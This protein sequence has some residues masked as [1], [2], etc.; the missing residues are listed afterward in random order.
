MKLRRKISVG[1]AV[2]LAAT[3]LGV[4]GTTPAFAAGRLTSNGTC[5]D[6]LDM[7]VQNV[8]DPIGVKV[9]IPSTDPTEVWSVTV[10]QQDYGA[11]TGGR[12]GD[13]VDVTGQF[14]PLVY[15][16]KAQGFSLDGG[17]FTNSE[18][19]THGFSYTATRT[20]PSPLTCTNTNGFWTNPFGTDEGPVSGNPFTRPDAAPLFAGQ[21]EADVG[22]ND[23]LLLM[24]QEM[25]DN[26]LG[27]PANNRFTVT[28]N[29]VAQTVTA[30]QIFN[31]SPPNQAV[32][33][34]TLA[35][36]IP[37]G[38]AV[39]ARYTRALTSGSASLRDLEGLQTA[40]FGPVNISVVGAAAAPQALGRRIR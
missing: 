33:D 6:L 34:L 23:V 30:V 18:G 38:A 12:I 3:T 19:L 27:I 37:S 16:P 4:A 20:S 8:G 39:T 14:L 13:P 11:S 1:I 2:A 36:P 25:L 7:R 22:S 24:D 15:D 5:G 21:S 10:I 9:A 31:D 28:V 35:S 40:S 32:L 26:G 17:F 29:G